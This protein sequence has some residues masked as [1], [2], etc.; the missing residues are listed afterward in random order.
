MVEMAQMLLLEFIFLEEEETTTSWI[1][2]VSATAA[3]QW[4]AFK[5]HVLV[6]RCSV[7]HTRYH[8]N[9]FLL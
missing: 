2:L 3:K 9:R 6:Q 1:H 7:A 5:I 8:S 4:N